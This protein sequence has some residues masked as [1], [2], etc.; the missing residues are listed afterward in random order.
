MSPCALH[1]REVFSVFLLVT[2]YVR[3]GF[4]DT[5]KNKKQETPNTVE[6][7]PRKKKRNNNLTHTCCRKHAYL[8]LIYLELGF[9]CPHNAS[10]VLNGFRNVA[11]ESTQNKKSS[12]DDAELAFLITGPTLWSTSKD[13]RPVRTP[14]KPLTARTQE[15]RGRKKREIALVTAQASGSGSSSEPE[16]KTRKNEILNE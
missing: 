6:F 15:L 7:R 1:D 16:S 10:A 9:I 2:R 8:F 11:D 12:L 5:C 14:L 13:K 3:R 4:C